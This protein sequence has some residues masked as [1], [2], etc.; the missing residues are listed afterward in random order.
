MTVER[1]EV[2]WI[3]TRTEYSV[4]EIVELSGLSRVLVDALVDRGVLPLASEAMP[5][6]A[7]ESVALARAARR[8]HEHFELDDRGLA[9]A[10]SLLRR[11]RA[12]ESELVRAR[13]E[14]TAGID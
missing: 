7:A 14:R 11:V 5:T 10:V 1:T 13:A 3:E 12:L 8:L 4:H 9:V 2:V 6:F